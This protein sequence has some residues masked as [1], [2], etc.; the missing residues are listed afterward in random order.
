MLELDNRNE[1]ALA[2]LGTVYMNKGQIK[3]SE[4][5]LEMAL[6]KNNKTYTCPYEGLGLLYFKQGKTREA[7]ASFKKAIEIN[8][9]IDYKKYNGLAK[10]YIKQGRVGEAKKLLEKSIQNYPYDSEAK[11]LLRQIEAKG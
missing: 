4:E 11:D 9:D 2:G 8:P 10:I 7:E 6:S 3:K 1:Y 5:L